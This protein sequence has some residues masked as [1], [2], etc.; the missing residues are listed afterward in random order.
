MEVHLV[1]TILAIVKSTAPMFF[2]ANKLIN[3]I[4]W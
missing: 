4:I 1:V 3:F 2:F